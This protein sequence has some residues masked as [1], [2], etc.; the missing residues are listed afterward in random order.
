MQAQMPAVREKLTVLIERRAQALAREMY[1]K[2]MKLETEAVKAEMTTEASRE[3]AREDAPTQ[4]RAEEASFVIDEAARLWA[5]RGLLPEDVDERAILRGLFEIGLI[6]PGHRWQAK[7]EEETEEEPPATDEPETPPP[8]PVVDVEAELEDA[9]QQ[10]ERERIARELDLP[11]ELWP[12]SRRSSRRSWHV[13]AD[14]RRPRT[15]HTPPP[16]Q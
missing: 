11:P 8:P 12:R 7:A 15:G 5:A 13:R 10:E 1:R 9:R 6:A 3:S 2:R 4:E 16:N 14:P